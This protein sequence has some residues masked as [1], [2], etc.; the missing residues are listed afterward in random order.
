[1]KLCYKEYDVKMSLGAIKYF[2]QKTGKDLWGVLLALLQTYIET[3]RESIVYR[4][5][6]LYETVD[7]ETASHMFKAIIDTP[8]KRYPIE[9][10]QD[11]MYRVGWRI[12]DDSDEM[13]EPWPFVAVAAAYEIDE[14]FADTVSSKKKADTS[15]Q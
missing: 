5:R 15:E 11:A 13:S 8:D 14:Q 1:M 4:M 2:K 12:T 10:I 9:E 3:E 7:F 6:K